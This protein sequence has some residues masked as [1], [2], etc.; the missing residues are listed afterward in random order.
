MNLIPRRWFGPGACFAAGTRVHTREGRV[1]IEQIE[2]GDWVLSKPENSGEQAYKRVVKTFALA[3]ERVIK[4]L[5]K[6][7]E[8]Q[9]ILH[10]IVTTV[11]HP[12]WVTDLGWTAAEDLY[13]NWTRENWLELADGRNV[14]AYD[15]SHI[16]VSDQTRVGWLPAY[17]GSMD[18]PGDLWDFVNHRLVANDVMA[19]QEVQDHEE[20][21]KDPRFYPFPDE[22]FLKLP[23]Y[24]LEVEDFHTYYVGK[25][26]VWVHNTNCV[27]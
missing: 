6:P 20:K 11:N 1:P 23:V 22:L 18:E 14:R 26:G 2:V 8:S 5:Y 21:F 15:T 9:E 4:V 7:D 10:P 13:Q 12:F 25:H 16:Y 27:E 3:P 24:N 17:S 19:L